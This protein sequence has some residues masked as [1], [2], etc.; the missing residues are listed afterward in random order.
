MSHRI[1]F[2]DIVSID[3]QE[4][5]AARGSALN[6][7]REDP[8]L[9]DWFGTEDALTEL[10]VTE[11]DYDGSDETLAAMLLAQRLAESPLVD[12]TD[13]LEDPESE[14]NAR[15]EVIGATIE[16]IGGF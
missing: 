11:D 9:L 14:E 6:A 4:P 5:E 1:D 15:F 10:D 2:E 16:K 12:Y 3:S 8:S 13:E 7:V